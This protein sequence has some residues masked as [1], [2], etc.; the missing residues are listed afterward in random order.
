MLNTKF[1]VSA[2]ARPFVLDSM[3]QKYSYGSKGEVVCMRPEIVFLGRHD[4]FVDIVI[5]L[6]PS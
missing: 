4:P 6:M 1:V 5:N 2:H 3:L